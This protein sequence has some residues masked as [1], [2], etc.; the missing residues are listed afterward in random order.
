MC[1]EQTPVS[2][3]LEMALLIHFWNRLLSE[4]DI[5]WLRLW[6][7]R[8]ADGYIVILLYPEDLIWWLG[9][10]KLWDSTAKTIMTVIMYN[11]NLTIGKWKNNVLYKI[12]A[13]EDWGMLLKS[14]AKGKCSSCCW[15]EN[16]LRAFHK[17]GWY[18]ESLSPVSTFCI[19]MVRG[20]H[21]GSL[22]ISVHAGHRHTE[23]YI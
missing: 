17:W 10:F 22:T 3:Y 4:S 12:I 15:K 8:A 16:F 2:V 19:S 13:Y 6:G 18:W 21:R 20:C 23:N 14:L 7:S 5:L 9:P 1:A 11:S